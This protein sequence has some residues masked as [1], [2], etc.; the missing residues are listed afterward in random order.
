MPIDRTG[1]NSDQES[2]TTPG[3]LVIAFLHRIGRNNQFVERKAPTGACSAVVMDCAIF[4]ILTDQAQKAPE[5]T[6]DFTMD[7]K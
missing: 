7:D 2:T 3:E 1:N 4:H 6:C 5:S